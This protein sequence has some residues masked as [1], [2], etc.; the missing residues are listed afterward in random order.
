LREAE[1]EFIQPTASDADDHVILR[2]KDG[3]GFALTTTCAANL[4][5]LVKAEHFAF[6]KVEAARIAFEKLGEFFHRRGAEVAQS[7]AEEVLEIGCRKVARAIEELVLEYQLDREQVVLVGGGGGAAS[8]V[9]FTAKL[10]NLD[11]RIARNAEVISPI[12]VAMAM[13]RDT[14]ER[15][16][17]DPTP[18]D[19]LKVRR[20]AAEAAINAGAVADSIEVQ[21][22][23]DK[24]RNLVRATA[25]GTTELRKR[26]DSQQTQGVAACQEIAARSMRLESKDVSLIAEAGNWFVFT[27]AQKVS[28]LFGLLTTQREM[29]RVMD[30]SGVI[31]LQRG[32]AEVQACLLPNLKAVITAAVEQLTDFGD[33]GRAIPDIFVLYGSRLANFSGL[34][35]LEQVLALSEVE[36]RSLDP[37]TKLI[38]IACPK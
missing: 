22:E 25:M 8:L 27:G 11:H 14:I 23:V 29:L 30:Y 36:L 16:I 12:G 7:F 18:E 4:L 9:P 32:T 5:R 28:S 15:N 35:D 24:R 21:I 33:A 38:V 17:V 26:D 2:C 20:E 19:I 31:R 1:I 13:V 10:M 3:K 6:G 37:I 34:A